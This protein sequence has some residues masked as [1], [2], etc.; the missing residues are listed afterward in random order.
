MELT[1]EEWKLARKGIMEAI[2]SGVDI[3]PRGKDGSS[4]GSP[5]LQSI[6]SVVVCP[7]ATPFTVIPCGAIRRPRP[8]VRSRSPHLLPP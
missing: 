2:S 6:I 1:Y 4:N 8:P 3:M 5:D 7:G